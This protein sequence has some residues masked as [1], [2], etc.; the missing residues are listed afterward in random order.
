M[1]W[2]TLLFTL[3]AISSYA[4]ATPHNANPQLVKYVGSNPG[5]SE[6]YYLDMLQAALKA[7][8]KIEG[9]F[10]IDFTEESLSSQRKRELMIEGTRV[11]VDRFIVD[12]GFTA[13][14]HSLLIKVNVPLL[15]GFLGYRVPLIRKGSQ[16]LFD[17]VKN[18]NDLRKIRM[19]MG[20]GWEGWLYEQ[21]GFSVTEPIGMTMLL[22]ML[23]AGRF[24]FVPLGATEIQ[25]EYTI[26]N[27]QTLNLYPEKNLL[28]HY[29]LSPYFFV[30]GK[31]PELARRLEIGLKK[32]A[33][34]GIEKKIFDKYYAAKLKDLN[35]ANRTIIEVINTNKSML[36]ADAD[37]MPTSQKAN[38]N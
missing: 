13:D 10:R 25:T 1:N 38:Q 33:K 4:S 6:D 36:V 3:L 14:E 15:H 22:K 20:K 16:H 21:N 34:N 37:V 31:H 11:N 29:N 30:S 5:V 7:T 35:F 2:R 9:D 26:E 17:N 28:I 24:D 27:N 8:Q 23:A 19:G 12:D 32:I 18:I